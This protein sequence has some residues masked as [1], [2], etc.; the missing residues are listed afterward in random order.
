MH[1]WVI[2]SGLA[3]NIVGTILIVLGDTWFSR[4][5]LIYLDALE[6]SLSKAVEMLRSG[7]KDFI[8]LEINSQRDRGQDRARFVK[9]VGWCVLTV[10]FLVQLVGGFLAKTATGSTR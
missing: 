5:V 1:G 7:G 4:S 8:A 9:L 10:G 2:F 3:L 6:G